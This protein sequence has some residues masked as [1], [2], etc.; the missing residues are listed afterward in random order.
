MAKNKR[1]SSQDDVNFSPE[2]N[3]VAK[4]MNTFNKAVTMI[5]RKKESKK[6]SQRKLKHKNGR[7]GSDHF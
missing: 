5:D 4:H 6:G 3:F 7:A 2:R 1:K